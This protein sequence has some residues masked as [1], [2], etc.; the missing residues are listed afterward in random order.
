MTEYQKIC[1]E[2]IEKHIIEADDIFDYE[3]SPLKDIYSNYFE[4]CQVYLINYCQEYNIQ[5]ARIYF[6]NDFSVNAR[7]EIS[8]DYSIIG[9]NMGLVQ[10]TY[11][12]LYEKNDIFEKSQDL[13]ETFAEVSKLI[14]IPLGFLM[15]QLTTLF[16]FHHELAHLVQKSPLLTTELT[17]QYNRNGTLQ[18]TIEKHVLEFDSD[19]HGADAICGQLIEHFNRLSPENQTLK[20]LS[21][22]LSMGIASMLSYI[23][24]FFKGDTKIYYKESSHP[25]PTIRICYIIDRFI[26][27]AITNLPV[28]IKI[29]QEILTR[30]G[31][32]ISNVFLKFQPKSNEVLGEFR[33]QFLEHYPAI[34]NYSN[35]LL[36]YSRAMKNLMINRTLSLVS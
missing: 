24:L 10:G 17:E 14:N 33:Q 27:T 29:N 12:L 22:L 35:E 31:L 20:N 26:N 23:L 4:Y 18:F 19:N 30:L 32:Q 2:L 5:P 34:Q 3:Y 8:N 28:S 36:E 16:T 11:D 13:P 15:F 9:I 6:H 1:K 21:V 25:H 7:A